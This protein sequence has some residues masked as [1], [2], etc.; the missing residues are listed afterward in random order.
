MRKRTCVIVGHVVPAPAEWKLSV[1]LKQREPSP[2]ISIRSG[3]NVGN[4]CA[5]ALFDHDQLVK[6][7]RFTYH[8][9]WTYAEKVPFYR[10]PVV[11]IVM[12]P[13]SE[14][15]PS[16]VRKQSWEMLLYECFLVRCE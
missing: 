5:P 16:S 2:R 1:V 4:S 10:L 13:R 3:L 15:A 11:G 12:H 6:Y 14:Q 7:R 9:I 8:E